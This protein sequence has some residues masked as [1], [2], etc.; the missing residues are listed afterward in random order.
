[1]VGYYVPLDLEEPAKW[2]GIAAEREIYG[3]QADLA[4]IYSGR[5]ANH[6]DLVESLHWVIITKKFDP[7]KSGP[8]L[9]GELQD[10]ILPRMSREQTAEAE[11]RAQAWLTRHGK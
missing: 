6:A 1:M 9:M 4:R 3:A 10:E 7:Y 2:L 11:R 5:F 8:D